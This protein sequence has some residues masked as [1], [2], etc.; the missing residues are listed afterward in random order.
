MNNALQCNVRL[1]DECFHV[2][3]VEY[4]DGL[5]LVSLDKD[6]TEI[7]H[8]VGEPLWVTGTGRNPDC[9][10]W[11]SRVKWFSPD[12]IAQEAFIARQMLLGEGREALC[13]LMDGGYRFNLKMKSHLLNYLNYAH[14]PNIITRV[15]RLGWIENSRLFMLPDGLAG[16]SQGLSFEYT[17]PKAKLSPPSGD[18]NEW[19][20]NVARLCLDNSRLVLCVSLVFAGPLLRLTNQHSFGIHLVG[21]SSIGKSTAMQV[22]ASVIGAPMAMIQTWFA[23]KV[24]LE[25]SAG[26][27][28]DSCLFLDEIGQADPTTLGDTIYM[29]ANGEGRTRA[30]VDLSQRQRPQWRI[31]FISNGEVDLQHCLGQA[32][33]RHRAGHDVRMLNLTADAGLGHGLF[34]QL[35]EFEN[36]AAFAKALSVCTSQFN[37]VAFRSFIEQ[38]IGTHDDAIAFVKRHQ[39][40]FVQ[41]HSVT[42]ADG[43]VQRALDAFALISAAGELAT[44]LQI[45]GWPTG[46]ASQA[47]SCLFRAWLNRR[48]AKGSLEEVEVLHR[49]ID[50]LEGKR[51][52]LLCE[53]NSISTKES[54]GFTDSS[55]LNLFTRGFKAL[56]DGL[57]SQQ[58]HQTLRKHGIMAHGVGAGL[59][60]ETH[61]GLHQSRVYKLSVSHIR[62]A[63][64]D[65]LKQQS[66]EE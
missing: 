7:Y 3:E 9:S 65:L 28:N 47:A 14:S 44:N 25:T 39:A 60:R 35:H 62:G 34:E 32:N 46:T 4:Q 8:Y 64:D 15:D 1:F 37:G 36:G 24:G 53:Q 23:T 12:G 38:L 11:G 63:F 13:R 59:P 43:Q 18:L 10:G 30:N 48:G 40:H 51:G 27:L 58:V 5:Y 57:Q 20:H 49:L 31:T 66:N 55:H 56:F 52:V 42:D 54:Y 45:T 2:G 41:E 26:A 50:L 17:G 21:P 22:A 29:L 16:H 33:K 6:N 19:Q 61:S